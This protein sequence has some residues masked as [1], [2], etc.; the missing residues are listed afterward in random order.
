MRIYAAILLLLQMIL[1]NYAIANN[2]ETYLIH[3]DNWSDYLY[4]QSPERSAPSLSAAA[5]SSILHE[6]GLNIKYEYMPMKRSLKFMNSGNELCILDKIKSAER[7]QSFSFSLPMNLFLSRRLYQ[8]NSLPKLSSQTI[9]LLNLLKA[10]PAH[11]I[12]ITS[13]ISYGENLDRIISQ[14]PKQQVVL[15]SSGEHGKGLIDM[16]NNHRAEYAL[17][18]P[19][20]LTDND[21]NLPANSYQINGTSPY[22]LGHLMCVKSKKMNQ[23]IK[24][25]NNKIREQLSSTKLLKIHK[26]YVEPNSHEAL[27]KYFKQLNL[28]FGS[29]ND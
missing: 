25:L 28:Q 4:Y 20:T 29:N 27:S 8:H 13:Q 9:N 11:K 21:A 22:I 10:Q 19:Q 15:R 12:L 14:I 7:I 5:N 2:K 6:L 1:F 23:F 17:F 26:Q 16:F 3:T 18:Y 24:V